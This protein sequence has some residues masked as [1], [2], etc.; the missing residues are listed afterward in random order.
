MSDAQDFNQVTKGFFQEVELGASYPPFSAFR[1]H[2]G[3]VPSIFRCQSLLPR[4]IEAEAGLAAAIH[5][6]VRALSCRQKERLLLPL[7]AAHRNGYWVAAHYQ[8]LCLLG[9]PEERLDQLVSDY[10]QADLSS[11]DMGLL[12]FALN[13]GTNGPFI[14]RKDIGNVQS[15]G[16]SNEIILE[17]ILIT[18]WSSLLSCLSTGLGASPDFEV[19]PI[20]GTA[21]LNPQPGGVDQAGERIGPY[22]DAPDLQ[23]SQFGPFEFF[24]EHLGFIPNLLRAQSARPDVIEAETEAFR[25]VMLT[26]DHLSRLQ[27]ELILLVVSAAN[28]NA[29]CVAVHS[30]ILRTLGVLPDVADK[31]AQEHRSAGLD[32]ADEALLDFVLKLASEP[33]EFGARDFASLRIYGF[34]DEQVLESVVV[35]SFANFLNTLEFGLGAKA[36]FVLRW[37]PSPIS[38]KVSNLPV[39]DVRHTGQGYAGDPDNETVVRVQNG[40]LDAFEALINR[41]S[42]RVYRTLLATLGNQEEARDAMQDTFLK[43]FQ[44]LGDFQG[45]SRF[46]TWL[47]SIAS[48]TGLQLLRERKRVQSLDDDGVETDEGFRPRQIRA[49]SDNPEQL[50]SKAEL[51][52]L[53]EEHV[54]KLPIKYRVVV[55]LRDIE[56]VSIEEAAV[57]LGLGIQAL[58]SRHL[59]GRLMLREALTPHFAAA[60]AGGAA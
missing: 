12:E 22:L 6:P 41:H 34:T 32:E 19:A 4:L 29:C 46:S 60:A 56:Q 35:T 28:R 24:R 33:S 20:P 53:V 26:D 36:D 2:F 50:C 7:A 31:I 42:R 15:Q 45:R 43:A 39:P 14:T 27:K 18:A 57:A 5:F 21:Q 13:L 44:H 16:W 48:N 30:E 37:E 23:T 58:K 40:D 17:T 54:M 8:L 1:E 47:V 52:A 25:L 59:R 49:W 55:M 38:E 51:R 9:E 11:A 10:R 3:F